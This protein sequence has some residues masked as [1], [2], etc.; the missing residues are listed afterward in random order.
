MVKPEDARERTLL[1]YKSRP[2]MAPAPQRMVADFNNHHTGTSDGGSSR[3][4]ELS[5]P[6]DTRKS[7]AKAVPLIT[8]ILGSG[9]GCRHYDV[10]TSWVPR[11]QLALRRRFRRRTTGSNTGL[12]T[13]G[14]E[15]RS[16]PESFEGRL[17]AQ[18]R[19]AA[20]PD[21]PPSSQN[22]VSTKVRTGFRTRKH[23]FLKMASANSYKL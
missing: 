1:S 6:V 2:S 16:R 4:L 13:G 3:S 9:F 5:E 23:R 20:P 19:S 7:G 21:P 18:S 10:L 17:L 22:R 8:Y 11:H 14:M 12:R 15:L